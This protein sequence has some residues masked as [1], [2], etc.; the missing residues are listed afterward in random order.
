[1]TDELVAYLLDD[2]PPERRAAVEA[3]LA[4]HPQ[5]AEELERLRACL[6]VDDESSANAGDP[7]SPIAAEPPDDL[8]RR[9]CSLVERACNGD[10]DLTHPNSAQRPTPAR[11]TPLSAAPEPT[12]YAGRRPLIDW[13][14]GGG[15]ALLLGCL[16]APALLESRSA[17]RGHVCQDNL[18]WL[19]TQLFDFQER[20]DQQLPTVNPG[21]HAGLYATRLVE[22]G[23]VD[24]RL[25]SQRIICPDSDVAN[26]VLAGRV[27]IVIP[28]SRQ[29]AAAQGQDRLRL[30][31]PARGF[32]AIRQGHYDALDNYHQPRFTGCERKPLLA[33]APD[34]SRPGW[35]G[36]NHP[37]GQFV[38][39]E[40]MS[41]RFLTDAYIDGDR[42]NMY[43]ND[44]GNPTPACD[45]DDA[46]LSSGVGGPLGPVVPVLVIR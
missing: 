22:Q 37:G 9:T 18:R 17:A 24:P 10:A 6:G 15:V 30:I 21:E 31:L 27:V 20:W 8:V 38:L 26:D 23:G 46:M 2:L 7:S 45:P 19:G 35:G 32:Y 11:L 13:T 12:R 41:V 3:M 33:D 4:T 25:L 43:A 36:A 40:S 5:W 29:L 1:M 42:D 34:Y 14:V 28:S 44:A 16:I 39:C